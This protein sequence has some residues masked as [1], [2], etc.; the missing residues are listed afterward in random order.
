MVGVYVILLSLRKRSS[1]IFF[2]FKFKN[3]TNEMYSRA[4]TKICVD[5]FMNIF[6]IDWNTVIVDNGQLFYI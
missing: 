1:Q 6:N 2:V 4:I 3:E 5:T